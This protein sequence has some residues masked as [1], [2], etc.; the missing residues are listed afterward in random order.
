M[1]DDPALRRSDL[2]TG[3]AS[4]LLV[5]PVLVADHTVLRSVPCYGLAVLD[6]TCECGRQ[7]NVRLAF[8]S[9]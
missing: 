5:A 6:P 3:G 9:L 2:F 7:A 1:R 4:T 8:R